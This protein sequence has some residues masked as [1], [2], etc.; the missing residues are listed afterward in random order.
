MAKLLAVIGTLVIC[1]GLDLLWQSRYE[2]RF[3]FHAYLK[4]LRAMLGWEHPARV[5]G[6]R[7]VVRRRQSALQFLLG[8]GFVLVLG[9][10]LIAAGVTL[11]FYMHL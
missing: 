9:P 1:A 11:M 6:I 2:L 7:E 3:W 4:I 10:I 8:M 5:L